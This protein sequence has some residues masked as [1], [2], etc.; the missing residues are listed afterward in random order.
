M[1]YLLAVVISIIL[2]SFCCVEAFADVSY[3]NLFLSGRGYDP[4]KDTW[5][6]KSLV[7][8]PTDGNA[9]PDNP[10]YKEWCINTFDNGEQ[11]YEAYKE[12]AFDIDYRPEPQKTDYWQTPIET[13]QS[14][15]GDCED[16]AFLFF[17]QAFRVRYRR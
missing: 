15:K 14:K 3:A 9:L 1:R 5:M 17:S 12:I 4:I 16:S 8:R 10:R 2:S 11:I 13:M 6:E 7:T